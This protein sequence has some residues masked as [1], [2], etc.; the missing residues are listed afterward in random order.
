MYSKLFYDE[1]IKSI[2]EG[3]ENE[4]GSMELSNGEKLNL[5]KR[6]TKDL[7]EGEDDD[8]KE[9]VVAKLKEKAKVMEDQK[10]D[11]DD[12]TPEQYLR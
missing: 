3:I 8:V 7:Y 5:R 6:I 12:R 9:L 10:H 11:E 2:V 1:K 4:L